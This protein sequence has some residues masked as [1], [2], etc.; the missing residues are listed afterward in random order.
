M[1]ENEAVGAQRQRGQELGPVGV[2]AI[3]HRCAGPRRSTGARAFSGRH[4]ADRVTLGQRVAHLRHAKRRGETS[5]ATAGETV[6]V[7]ANA[8]QVFRNHTERPTRLLCLCSPAG[9][10]ELFRLLGVP[11]SSR[12]EAPPPLDEAG[13]GAFLARAQV[14]APRYRTEL[15]PP[16]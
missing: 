5:A 8:P 9:Q 11:L 14:L 12:T 13:G 10:E 3:R 2:V 16:A 15:L 4:A 6:N 1:S 7:P